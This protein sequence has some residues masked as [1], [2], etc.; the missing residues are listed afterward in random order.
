M[1]IVGEIVVRALTL[2]GDAYNACDCAIRVLGT[3]ILK[4]FG[5]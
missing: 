5:I 1:G 3:A 4:A 2:T